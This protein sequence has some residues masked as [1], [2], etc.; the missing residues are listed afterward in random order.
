MS[1]NK[2]SMSSEIPVIIF[3]WR[4]MSLNKTSMSFEIPII[5]FHLATKT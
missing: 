2:T 4:N 1:L 3:H 5:I